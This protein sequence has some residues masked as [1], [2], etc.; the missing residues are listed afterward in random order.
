MLCGIH[1]R[2]KKLTD[3]PSSFL[4]T[5]RSSSSIFFTVPK[6]SIC[7]FLVTV[8]R[9]CVLNFSAAAVENV[10]VLDKPL[11]KWPS[12]VCDGKEGTVLLVVGKP[13]K[14]R[15]V[16]SMEE[17]CRRAVWNALERTVANAV[18]PLAAII[19]VSF[20]YWF[21]VTPVEKIMKL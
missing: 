13:E 6:S 4:S 12:M 16:P 9:L 3:L 11:H 5:E 15:W 1:S 17:I 20:L 19:M 8:P 21:V 10:R 7:N 14:N 2:R 18:D